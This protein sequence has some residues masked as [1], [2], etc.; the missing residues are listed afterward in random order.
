MI[1]FVSFLLQNYINSL[2][3]LTDFENRR[4]RLCLL[5]INIV[6]FILQ[7]IKIGQNIANHP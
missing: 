5:Y 2:T 4:S 6:Y 3:L 1:I 7:E